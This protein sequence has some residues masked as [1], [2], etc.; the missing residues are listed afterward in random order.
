MKEA[1]HSSETKLL[2]G[3]TRRHIPEVGILHSHRRE[4]LNLTLANLFYVLLSSTL[5]CIR[6]A[7]F[8]EGKSNAR[9]LRLALET[10][11]VRHLLGTH[12]VLY[13]IVI[14]HLRFI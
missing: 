11:A 13:C 6:V 9:V 14:A 8:L 4:N 1:I 2:T 3:G 12:Y 10:R 7:K 5:A